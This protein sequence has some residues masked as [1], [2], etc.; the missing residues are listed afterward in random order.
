MA[1]RNLVRSGWRAAS[2]EELEFGS[3]LLGRLLESIQSELE[4]DRTLKP[5]TVI[6]RAALRVMKEILAEGKRRAE[7]GPVSDG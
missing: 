3:F 6:S 7:K 1:D 2:E 4:A 5:L